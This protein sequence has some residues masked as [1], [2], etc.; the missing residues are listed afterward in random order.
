MQLRPQTKKRH[1]LYLRPLVAIT[2]LIAIVLIVV[3]FI[4]H[5]FSVVS[6]PNVTTIIGKN[7][8]LPVIPNTKR[9]WIMGTPALNEIA[10]NPSA[11]KTIENDTIFVPVKKA[12]RLITQTNGLHIVPVESFTSEA[13]L[14]SAISSN[15]IN[16]SVKVLLYDN[17][18]WSLTPLTEQQ[19]IV[20]YYKQAASI[21]HKHGYLLIGTPVSKTNPQADVQIAP[22][23][24]VLDIQSQYDQA[25]ASN[26]ASHVLPLAQAARK[27]NS[28]LIILSG[29]STNP[30]AGI[31]TPQQ[32][33]NDATAVTNTV[34]GFWLNIPSPGIACPRCNAPQPQ[35]GIEFLDMLGNHQ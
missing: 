3:F 14:A 27:V 6:A 4:W 25:V 8:S 19:N 34:Q 7:S 30:P 17:E 11:R 20:R 1:S 23:V 35:I 5:K 12:V 9:Y 22:F 2:A 28:S 26:Y 13:D 29:L 31:P 24:D 18:N 21:A 10:A 15:K 33:L 16:P 32:L